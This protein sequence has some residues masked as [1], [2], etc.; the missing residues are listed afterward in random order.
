MAKSYTEPTTK[1]RPREVDA[2]MKD[3]VVILLV[4]FEGGRQEAYELFGATAE[5]ERTVQRVDDFR[6][7]DDSRPTV[8]ES[9][10]EY[11]ITLR[12]TMGVS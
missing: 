9:V 3:G 12:G 11:A 8:R 7:V 2:T 4:T 1:A 5:L 10:V 6:R